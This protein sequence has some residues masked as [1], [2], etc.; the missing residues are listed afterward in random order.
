MKLPIKFLQKASG[1]VED[2][3]IGEMT[4]KFC[5]KVNLFRLLSLFEAH[6]NELIIRSTYKNGYS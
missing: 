3:I 2:G 5:Y 6:Y 1:V 4:L